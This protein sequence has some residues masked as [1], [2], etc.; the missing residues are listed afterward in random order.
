MSNAATIPLDK[1]PSLSEI[2]S[3]LNSGKHLNRLQ[4]HDLWVEL[5]REEPQYR[6]LFE[7]L[8]FTL[9]FDQRGFAWLHEKNAS[10]DLH[11][12]S[13][14]LA[15]FFMLIFQHQADLGKHLRGFAEWAID[16]SVLGVIFD[17]N[18]TLL[19]ASETAPLDFIEKWPALACRYGFAVT[20]HQGWRLLPAVWRYLDLFQELAADSV[21][22][23][24]DHHSEHEGGS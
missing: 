9:R 23:D 15:L 16:R 20:E 4:D 8:G 14:K 11:K 13:R 17:K 12:N 1:L 2:F 7:R 22:P 10:T 5:E 6:I 19:E 21:A 18:R 3:H 24:H